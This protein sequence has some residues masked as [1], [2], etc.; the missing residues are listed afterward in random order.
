M[1]RFFQ[2]ISV[3]VL[4]V[5]V[6]GCGSGPNAARIPPDPAVPVPTTTST[7]P[8]STH[9]YQTV[10]TALDNV[11]RTAVNQ[12][13]AANAV[14]GFNTSRD[15]LVTALDAQAD[16]LRSLVPPAGAAGAN[17]RLATALDQASSQVAAIESSTSDSADSCGIAELAISQAKREVDTILRGEAIGAQL[18]ALV[19]VKFTVGAFVPPPPPPAPQSQRPP[20]GKIVVRSGPRGSGRLDITNSGESDVAV[21]V[22]TGEP[23]KPQ[24]MIYVWTGAKASISGI[25]GSY[26]VYFKSGSNWDDARH[27]FTSGCSFEKFDEPF[28]RNAHWEISLEKSTLG[29][30]STSTVPGY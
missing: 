9:D 18:K 11:L 2:S 13:H 23:S 22:V 1:P 3:G 14:V 7:P 21:S 19:A 25:S 8:L 16:A 12:V 20:N 27:G 10:L 26:Q 29:N 6:T 30:A 5:A 17:P 28:D 4:L 24:V 15:A